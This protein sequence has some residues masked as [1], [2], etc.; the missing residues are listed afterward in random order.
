MSDIV[1]GE[2]VLGKIALGEVALSET[3]LAKTPVGGISRRRRSIT[4]GHQRLLGLIC[5]SLS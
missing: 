5:L 4:D 1:L 3:V 2:A